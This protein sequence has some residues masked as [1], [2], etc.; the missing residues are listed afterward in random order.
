MSSFKEMIEYYRAFNNMNIG[1][2]KE[3]YSFSSLKKESQES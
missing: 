2:S 1:H 3:P